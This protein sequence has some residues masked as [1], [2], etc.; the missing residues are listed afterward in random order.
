MPTLRLA[1]RVIQ[2]VRRSAPTSTT[3]PPRP[4]RVSACHWSGQH[5]DRPDGYDDVSGAVA[6]CLPVRVSKWERIGARTS[7]PSP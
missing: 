6:A 4:G 7:T 3:V 1:N 5:P 2:P